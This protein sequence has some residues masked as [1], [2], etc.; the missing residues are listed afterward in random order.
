VLVCAG[1][2][3]VMNNFS[4]KKNY[5]DHICFLDQA[6]FSINSLEHSISQSTPEFLDQQQ[7]TVSKVD[8]QMHEKLQEHLQLSKF[9]STKI[10][11]QFT[12]T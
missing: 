6:D 5:S 7:Q 11:Q 12:K 9:L 1:V 10:G 3:T 4:I 2:A 8:H